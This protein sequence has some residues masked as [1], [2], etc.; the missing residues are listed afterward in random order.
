M[1]IDK[2]NI[3]IQDE[4][5]IK[6]SVDI[7]KKEAFGKKP[8]DGETTEKIIGYF[9]TLSGCLTKI[10]NLEIDSRVDTNTPEEIL[11]AI[12]ALELLIDKKYKHIKLESG[13]TI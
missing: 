10:V 1:N 5:N 9:G 12:S 13:V 2:Y 7:P 4:Y 6:L 11:K 3:S 8:K